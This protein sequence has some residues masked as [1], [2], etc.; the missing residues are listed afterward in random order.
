MCVKFLVHVNPHTLLWQS[1]KIRLRKHWFVLFKN[2]NKGPH[3]VVEAGGADGEDLKEATELRGGYVHYPTLDQTLVCILHDPQE[4]HQKI[5]AGLC[6]KRTTAS[7]RLWNK[8]TGLLLSI[9]MVQKTI[10]DMH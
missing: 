9:Q 1:I 3:P 5:T 4:T 10:T 2:L 7:T 6:R 8:H